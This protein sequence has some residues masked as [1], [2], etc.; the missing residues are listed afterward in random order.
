[1]TPGSCTFLTRSKRSRRPLPLPNILPRQEAG[2]VRMAFDL[3]LHGVEGRELG[4]KEI[5]KHLT[6]KGLLDRGKPWR[7]QK[8]QIVL[9]DS[10]YMGDYFTNIRECGICG[11]HMTLVTGKGGKYRYYK[12]TNRTSKGNYACT[13]GNVPMEKLDGIVLNQLAE[14]VFAKDR[15]QTLMAELR[16]RM[17][18]SKD[19]QQAR[20]DEINRQIKQIEKKQENLL[21]AIEMGTIDLD[22]MTQRRAQQHKTAREALLIELASV[23]RDTAPMPA[24]EYLKASQVD[25]FGKVL[26]QKLLN[27]DSPLVKSYLNILVDEIVVE[28]KT[29]TI[30]GSYAALAETMQQIKMGNLNQVPTFN[31]DWCARRDSNS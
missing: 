20:I 19:D 2:I 30:K 23:R 8:V 24:V 21:N 29:A 11:H 6:E 7:M 31:P 22:E 3:Y 1:M 9:S 13:S 25:I 14:K 16:L 5:A 27:A 10:L 15:L 12:C 28:N 17:K 26:R 4:C 18:S